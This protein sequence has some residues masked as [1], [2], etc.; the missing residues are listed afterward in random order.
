[1]MLEGLHVVPMASRRTGKGLLHRNS[2]LAIFDELVHKAGDV[3]QDLEGQIAQWSYSP[4]DGFAWV[5]RGEGDAKV[6][7]SG[8][9]LAVLAWEDSL[10]GVICCME[11]K[12]VEMADQV[13]E[14]LVICVWF[15]P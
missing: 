10:R 1:M 6:L 15:E 3:S 5:A 13:C 8:L 7:A 2:Q 11:S 4:F 9:Q 14:V 12:R